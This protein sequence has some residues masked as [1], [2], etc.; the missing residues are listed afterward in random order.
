MR[1]KWS[2]IFLAIVFLMS[3]CLTIDRHQSLAATIQ[4]K[5]KNN[6]LREAMRLVDNLYSTTSETRESGKLFS[7][8]KQ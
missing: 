2:I 4:A 5:S 1:Q 3:Y 8:V 7:N 6:L